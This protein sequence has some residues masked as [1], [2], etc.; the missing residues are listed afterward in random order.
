MQHTKVTKL[1][2]FDGLKRVDIQ[3]AAAGDIVC[4]AGIEDITIGETITD[5]EHQ[6]AIPPI[7]IDEPTV[8]MIFGVNTSPVA[9]REGQYVTSRQLKDR[10]DRE[11]LGNVS[12]RVEPTDTPEQMKVV[13]RGELQLS[14]L[15]EMMR[16]EGFEMQV[17]RPD[18]VTK[19]LKGVIV[20]PVEEL[21]IDV[22]ED[23]QGVVIAQVGERKG[24][25]TKMVNNGSGR[26]RLEF[27]IPARGLIGFRSQF[28]TDTKGTGIM[29][30]IFS[31][32]EPWH[33]AIP[34]RA[35]GA[36]VA[37]R[38]GVATSYAIFNLQERGE[39]FIDP[40]TVG[41]RRH[42]HRRERAAERHGRQR[43]EGKEADEHARVERRRGD[44]PDS[45]AQAR[46]RAGD[47]VHQRRRARRGDAVEHPPAQADPGVEHAAEG[48][49]RIGLAVRSRGLETSV[50]DVQSPNDRIG[51]LSVVRI[52]R[53][54]A[55]RQ[56]LHVRPRESR[57]VGIRAGRS[58]SSARTSG[59]RRSSSARASRC[60]S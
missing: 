6:I 60:G 31:S 14:I 45:A 57:A 56:V 16:R 15:I 55:R 19:E 2:A 41:L 8:S 23:H 18:I 22:P 27:R 54:R 59:S 24:V 58:G 32:W 21:V 47:R 33:G 36:L 42:G 44:P 35:N 12:I 30:H 37:D 51:R 34:A 10:L 50:V 4:L 3:E 17:S 53:R 20:E 1:Y 39:I 43:H 7:A 9:G 11:L 38:A 40:A 25:M 26:V 52:A 13:G 48:C 5:V 29:N 46:P 28:M 49:Q